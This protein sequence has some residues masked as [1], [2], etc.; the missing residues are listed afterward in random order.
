MGRSGLSMRRLA[1]ILSGVAIL[2]GSA[3]SAVYLLVSANSLTT[4]IADAIERSTGRSVTIDSAARLRLW[5]EF[6]IS[7]SGVKLANPQVGNGT[8]F[9]E[10]ETMQMNISPGALIRR[11]AEIDEIKL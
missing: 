2:A 4:Q 9:A 5:P 10:V 8:A 11:R 3:L 6:G 1:V 7:F